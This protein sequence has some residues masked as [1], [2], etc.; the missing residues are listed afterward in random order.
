MLSLRFTAILDITVSFLRHAHF[1]AKASHRIRM[2]PIFQNLL[3][4]ETA[5]QK[6]YC[7]RTMHEQYGA[8]LVSNFSWLSHSF[9]LIMFFNNHD[10]CL[11]SRN[12]YYSLLLALAVFLIG[13]FMDLDRRR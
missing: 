1:F 13:L 12:L 11:T 4:K 3:P 6:V 7:N 10:W 2:L 5:L 8:W 9:K